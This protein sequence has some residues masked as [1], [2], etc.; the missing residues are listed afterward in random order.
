[1]TSRR[2]LWLVPAAIVALVLQRAGT[3]AGPQ[4]TDVT[5]D[6]A[7]LF[8]RLGVDR[9]HAAGVR[10]RGVKVAVID[11]GFRGYRS[12]AGSTLPRGVLARGFRAD[13]D[14]EARDS[15]HGILCGEVIH[16]LAPDAELLFTNWEPDRPETFVR[17]V[18]WARQQGARVLSCS[19][20]MPCWSDGEGGGPVHAALAGVMGTGGQQSDVLGFACAGNIAQRHWSGPFHP[21]A[22]GYH[23]WRPGQ[24]DNGVVPWDDERVSVELCWP[25]E[26]SY[27]LSVIDAR[28]GAEIGQAP[29]Q[30]RAGGHCAVVRFA[31]K[32]DGRYLVRVRSSERSGSG[33]FHLSVLGGWLERFTER[34]SIAFPADGPEFVAVGAVDETGRRLEYS[35]CGPNSRLPKP[36]FVAPVPFPGVGRTKPFTGT[37]AAAPQAAALA[38]LLLGRHPEWTPAQARAALQQAAVDID[39]PGH[40]AETGYGLLRLPEER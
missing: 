17:A 10:G 21:G 40:D 19:V 22:D 14:L 36:D 31:P 34:G 28:T 38:A 3:A 39:P 7:G 15:Q 2:A 8:A 32:R 12:S 33:A 37:S 30:S 26:A 20:I 18:A 9:W 13:G 27:A 35:S 4:S 1:M 6:R 23:E 5:R 29:A 25:T 11:S 16:A 24:R